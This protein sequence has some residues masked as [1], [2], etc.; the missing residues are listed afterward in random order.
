MASVTCGRS[1][2]AEDRDQRRNPIRSFP[3][4]DHRRRSRG[5]GRWIGPP[6]LGLGDN[7]PLSVMRWKFLCCKGKKY[8]NLLRIAFST[9]LIFFSGGKPPD[10]NWEGTAPLQTTLVHSSQYLSP[11]FNPTPTPLYE[12]TFIFYFHCSSRAQVQQMEIYSNLDQSQ[13]NSNDYW[14]LYKFRSVSYRPSQWRAHRA[15]VQ[16]DTITCRCQS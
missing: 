8:Q 7:P 2:T 3:V 9:K 10:P 4:R 15:C 6:L 11:T 1:L 16:A 13:V 12:T 14:I 5:G